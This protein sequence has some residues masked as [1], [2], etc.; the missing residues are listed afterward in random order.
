MEEDPNIAPNR[1]IKIKT[2]EAWE[3]RGPDE[4]DDAPGPATYKPSHAAASIGLR[5]GQRKPE[6]GDYDS[7]PD[8]PDSFRT[9]GPPGG[10][11]GEQKGV[12]FA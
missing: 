11:G 4:K 8:F 10:P 12:R 5:V 7:G 3:R 2:R 6:L 9:R 1:G